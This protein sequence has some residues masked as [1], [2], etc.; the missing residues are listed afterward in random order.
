[1]ARDMTAK[2]ITATKSFEGRALKA[3]RDAVGVWTIGYGITNYDEFAV[4]YLGKP[5]GAGMVIT[6][7]Q[8]DYL[9]VE[10]LRHKYLPRVEKHLGSQATDGEF[11]AAG[12]FDFNT[13]AVHKASWVPKCRAHQDYKAGL[14]S[15]NKA[16]GKV[17]RGLV[18]RREREYAIAKFGDYG[19]EGRS[20][21][22]TITT[23]AS[24]HETG[25]VATPVA[26][27]VAVP[28]DHPDHPLV[29][30]PGMLRKGDSGPEVADLQE[31]LLRP[32]FPAVSVTST[33]DDA[34]DK[35][36]RSFQHAHPQLGL[37]GVVG[38]ATR[39]SLQREI[40]GKRK[41]TTS[42]ATTAT[43]SLATVAADQA[44]GGGLPGWAYVA[45][46]AVVLG[47]AVY[48]GWKYRDELL[49]MAKRMGGSNA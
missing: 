4:K 34:T 3:Y 5:I 48:Y 39:K 8:A 33:F 1:M 22:L 13:G 2:G 6:D 28:T 40:D 30:T 32:L 43:P 41:L 19:P 14:L 24:G 44:T 29:G 25:A 35:A 12:S 11:D 45:L 49:G 18:R 7:E 16:G 10:S 26:Q 31:H 21:P 37:D 17:L 38:P 27:P 47:V 46:A 20:A 15:W 36:V 42:T 23:N 9:L